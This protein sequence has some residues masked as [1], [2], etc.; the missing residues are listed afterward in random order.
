MD[1][2]LQALESGVQHQTESAMQVLQG[3]LLRTCDKTSLRYEFTIL[4]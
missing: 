3:K 1:T 2:L 4:L